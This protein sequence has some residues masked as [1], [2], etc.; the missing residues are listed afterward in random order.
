M[1]E[2]ISWIEYKGEVLF[3][4]K[5][6]LETSRGKALKKHLGSQFNNDVKGHGAIKWY[7]KMKPNSGGHKECTDFSVTKNFPKEIVSAIKKGNFGG[8]GIAEQLLTQPAWAEYEKIKQT[9]FWKL[10]QSTKN[11]VTAWR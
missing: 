5:N 7:Y 8:I 4:T 3:L 2:F 1:C 6:E 10:F 9:A 11:R